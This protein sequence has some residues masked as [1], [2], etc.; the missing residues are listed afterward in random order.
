M[1]TDMTGSCADRSA[2]VGAGAEDLRAVAAAS[3]VRSFRRGQVVFTRSDPSDTVIVVISGQVKVVIRSA[4]GGE[5][6]LAVI[7]AGGLFGELGVADNG[8]GP[9]T[10]RPWRNASYC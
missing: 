2:P 6:T 1:T 4:D 7:H 9:P 3:R 5:L 8:P 10:P